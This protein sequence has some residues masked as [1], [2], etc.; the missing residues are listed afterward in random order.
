G[1]PTIPQVST[2]PAEMRAIARRGEWSGSTGGQCPAYQQANLVILPKEVGVEFAAFCT[3]N[4]KP[5]PLIEITPPGDPEPAR[6]APGADLR[7]TCGGYYYAAFICKRPII[8]R[9]GFNP[10]M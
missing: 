7:M 5:C 2:S 4:P 8:K 3:R 9:R 6:L 1:P 10:T